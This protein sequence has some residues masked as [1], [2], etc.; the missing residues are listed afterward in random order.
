[1]TNVKQQDAA[2]AVN[3]LADNLALIWEGL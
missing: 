2:R 1:L 3:Q